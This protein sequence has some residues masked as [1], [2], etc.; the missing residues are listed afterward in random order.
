MYIPLSDVMLAQ[1]ITNLSSFQEEV[2]IKIYDSITKYGAALSF[3]L[4][5]DLA[6]RNVREILESF[7]WNFDEDHFER[8][9][10]R[11][12]SAQIPLNSGEIELA[13][14]FRDAAAYALQGCVPQRIGTTLSE[15]KYWITQ[16]IAKVEDG[17]AFDQIFLGK[18]Y[19]Y[20][21]AAVLA[22]GA[23]DLETPR[24]PLEGLRLL[25]GLSLQAMRNAISN[26]G[27]FHPDHRQTVPAEEARQWI[28]HRRSFCVSRWK[29]LVD[30]QY[31][32]DVRDEAITEDGKIR[33]PQAT[34]GD[35]FV[36]E[37]IMRSSRGKR[38]LTI[39]IGAKG[40]ERQ[41]S[42][43]YEALQA[44]SEEEIARWRRPNAQGHWGIVRG[45][46]AWVVVSKAE[47]DR[48]I[49]DRKKTLLS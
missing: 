32:E 27:V 13:D 35:L 39:T 16:L 25:G 2:G 17:M 19:S 6:G 46:G 33:V 36:P 29:N 5:D 31:L 9:G 42:N 7:L 20:L 28:A 38:S 14:I 24:A 49:E 23:I 30:D 11:D 44:L 45:R 40:H 37:K 48:Q 8:L 34:E 4:G 22:R 47:I 21:W 15:R 12:F 26:D 41:F 3:L 18:H 43:Y 1:Q 10:W